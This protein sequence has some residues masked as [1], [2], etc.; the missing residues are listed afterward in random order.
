MLFYYAIVIV[1]YCK[2]IIILWP[3]IIL[4]KYHFSLIGVLIQGIANNQADDLSCNRLFSAAGSYP[5]I[6]TRVAAGH[7]C[8]LDLA[9]LDMAVHN[10]CPV[11]STFSVFCAKY[12][13][14]AIH[15]PL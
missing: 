3:Q 13:G 15:I 9:K 8:H 7:A 5:P 12:V 11:S 1:T 14:S 2:L 6:R 10:C 4:A